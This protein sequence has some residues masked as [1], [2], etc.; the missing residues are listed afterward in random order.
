MDSEREKILARLR[1]AL[2]GLKRQFPL[3]RLA[4]FGSIVRGQASTGSD[5][6]ILADVEPSIGLDFVT[7]ADKLEEL[8]GHKIDLVSRRA[9]KPLL[10]K[11]IEPEINRC[12]NVSRA[13]CSTIFGLRSARKNDTPL[14]WTR[15]HFLLMRKR[16]TQL[17]AT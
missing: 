14:A 8:T 1:A 2:P 12:L 10:W 11:Q 15:N 16:S 6:D 7:L 17:Y 4:L 5:I 13:F 9:I 3:R